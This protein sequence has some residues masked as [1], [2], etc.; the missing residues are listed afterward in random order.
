MCILQ[1]TDLKLLLT[2]EAVTDLAMASIINLP[3]CIPITFRN[4]YTPIAAAGTD[5][6]VYVDSFQILCTHIVHIAAQQYCSNSLKSKI[7]MNRN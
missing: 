2:P 3:Q 6:Q 1:I 5:A 7:C 4:S